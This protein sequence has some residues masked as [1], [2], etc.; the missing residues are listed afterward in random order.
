MEGI[1][2]RISNVLKHGLPPGI[3]ES[4]PKQTNYMYHNRYVD[5]HADVRKGLAVSLINL[6]QVTAF[7][8]WI[9]PLFFPHQNVAFFGFRATRDSRLVAFFFRRVNSAFGKL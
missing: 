6:I 2:K 4:A 7:S 9:F 5:V 8:G 3:S 1:T